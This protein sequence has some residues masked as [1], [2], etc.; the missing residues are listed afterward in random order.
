MI[1]PLLVVQILARNR[2]IQLGVIRDFI[3]RKL[4]ADEQSIRDVRYLRL[5]FPL[6]SIGLFVFCCL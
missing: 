5:L 3:V 4:E 6:C 1:P 2:D